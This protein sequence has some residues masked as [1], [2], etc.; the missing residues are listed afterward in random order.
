MP[1]AP[2]RQKRPDLLG[3]KFVRTVRRHART[4]HHRE[5]R[6]G[7]RQSAGISQKTFQRFIIAG[8][9]WIVQREPVPFGERIDLCG[10]QAVVI[11]GLPHVYN[12]L[13]DNYASEQELTLIDSWP[14]KPAVRQA[15]NHAVKPDWVLS[16]KRNR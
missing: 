14:R 10:P 2:G 5:P 3:D 13:F 12:V 7:R 4:N 1:S 11:H 6:G 8:Q 15:K 16:L 9:G